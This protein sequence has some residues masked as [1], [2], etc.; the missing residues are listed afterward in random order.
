M[1]SALPL[2]GLLVVELGT[3]VAGAAAGMVPGEPPTDR[4]A[5]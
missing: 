5:E 3:S 4:A 2:S 1:M